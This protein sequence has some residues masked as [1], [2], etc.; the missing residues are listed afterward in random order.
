MIPGVA[1]M[2]SIRHPRYEKEHEETHF[3]LD[4]VFSAFANMQINTTGAFVNCLG[5]LAC[6]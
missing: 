5:W 6:L 1:R 2:G 4:F 3:K